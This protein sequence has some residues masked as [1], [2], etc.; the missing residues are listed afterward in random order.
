MLLYFTELAKTLDSD[1]PGW[2]E[3]T[4]VQLDG[5]SYH[6]SRE[7]VQLLRKLAIPFCISAPY[8]YEG[9]AAE[10]VF[11]MLKSGDLNPGGLQLSK[12]KYFVSSNIL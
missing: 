6:Y 7:T 2:R 11:A 4:I 1:R 3:D 8:S 12:S 5:A 9:A 10:L